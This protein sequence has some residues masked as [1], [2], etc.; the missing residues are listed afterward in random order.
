MSQLAISD[1]QQSQPVRDVPGWL[2]LSIDKLKLAV[3]QK[4]ASAVE[5]VS[6]LD[7]GTEGEAE[8]GWLEQNGALWPAYCVD[9][10]L[11]LQT[12]TPRR[13]RF[14]IMFHGGDRFIGLLCDQVRMLQ[15]DDDLELNNMPECLAEEESPLQWIA[16][17][18]GEV[19]AA[20]KSGALVDYLLKLEAQY[21]A[22]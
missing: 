15:S 7:V 13:R 12:E 14:C 18:D 20:A 3:P 17:L 10:Q 5:L 8:V 1:P 11:K 9:T 4:D 2:I 19:T 16:M 21:G 22:D 6:A